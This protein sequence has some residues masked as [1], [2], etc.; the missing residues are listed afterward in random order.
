MPATPYK[1]SE[2]EQHPTQ[3]KSYNIGEQSEKGSKSLRVENTV[4]EPR[5]DLDTPQSTMAV[6][7]HHRLRLA[8]LRTNERQRQLKR[9]SGS[10]QGRACR[11]HATASAPLLTA[12]T[13]TTN[14]FAGAPGA[15]SVIFAS[16]I[17]DKTFFIAA[18]LA[19]RRGRMP[20]LLGSMA[21]LTAMAAVSV[22]IGA[23]LNK[24]PAAI[25]R[26]QPLTEH[27]A[28]GL[29]L[30]FGVK[31]LWEGLHQGDSELSEAEELVQTREKGM[32]QSVYAPIA[33]A[34]SLTFAAEWG[35][36]S[37]LATVALGAARSPF[38]VFLGASMGHLIATGLAVASGHILSQRLSHRAMNIASGSIFIGLAIATSL[39]LL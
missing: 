17:G 39:H 27:L 8:G 33:E 18:L 23:V 21:A 22:G 34:F 38:G 25:S 37:M 6:R 35:D 4:T 26:L 16:E 2:I 14:L 10:P 1:F 32:K 11:A 12:A 24:L 36:R 20:A 31:T 9:P 7:Q 28:A 13:A 30:F 15:L 19:A 5:K 29:L 3:T